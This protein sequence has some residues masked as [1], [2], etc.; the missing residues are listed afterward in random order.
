MHEKKNEK[1][2]RKIFRP[3]LAFQKKKKMN[4]KKQFKIAKY[5]GCL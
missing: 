4:V 3:K 2:I 1:L 5:M